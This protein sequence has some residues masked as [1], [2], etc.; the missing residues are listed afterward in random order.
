MTRGYRLAFR[1]LIESAAASLIL[2][3]SPVP[4]LAREPVSMLKDT[5]AESTYIDVEQAAQRGAIA[6]WALG[7]IEEHGPHLPLGTDGYIASAQLRTVRKT[8]KRAGIQSLIVPPY[9]WAVNHVT[10]DFPGSFNIRPET[11]VELI[12][13]VFSGLAKAGFKN[14]Y[15]ITGHFDA[16]HGKAIAEAVRQANKAGII[17]AHFVVP[18]QLGERLELSPSDGQFMLVEWPKGAAMASIDLHAGADE[19]SAMTEIAPSLVK[20]MLARK[21]PDTEL[22]AAQVAEWRKGGVTAR[23]LTPSG[24]LGAPAKASIREGR[25]QLREQALTYATAIIAAESSCSSA[26]C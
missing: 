15:C 24:Y 10:D 13:D 4:S 21:L 5:M 2:V 8:L 9:Y 16:T 26:N 20:R 18:K 22:S 6:L 3:I 14:V 1:F 23:L 12:L 11:M 7:S 25:R 17:R 19:T